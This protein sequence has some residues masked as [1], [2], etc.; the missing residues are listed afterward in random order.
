MGLE[1]IQ[2]TMG[3]P[4]VCVRE[5]MLNVLHNLNIRINCNDDAPATVGSDP[6]SILTNP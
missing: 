3:I 1:Y 4:S 2:T 5:G 6:K